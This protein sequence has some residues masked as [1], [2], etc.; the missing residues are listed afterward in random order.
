MLGN[1]GAGK[2]TLIGESLLY[3]RL[4]GRGIGLINKLRAYE[5]QDQGMD[6]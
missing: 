4:E 1:N 2:N 5:L 6:T 3:M